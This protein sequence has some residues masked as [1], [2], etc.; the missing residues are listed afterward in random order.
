MFRK[1]V[2]KVD[3]LEVVLAIIVAFLSITGLAPTWLVSPFILAL[4]AVLS[5]AILKN[6]NILEKIERNSYSN[7]NVFLDSFNEEEVDKNLEHAKEVIILGTNLPNVMHRQYSRIEQKLRNGDKIKILIVKSD[8]KLSEIIA[9]RYYEP[10]KIDSILADSN[11]TIE[12]CKELHSI[13]KETK[14][15]LKFRFLDYLPP[16]GAIFVNPQD[17]NGI[18]YL[19]FYTYKT[20]DPKKPKM[21]LHATDSKWYQLFKEIIIALW[22]HANETGCGEGEIELRG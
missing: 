14:G 9:E 19:W 3:N 2:L 6:R 18:I 22:D 12:L 11:T 1:N 15:E 20:R 7:R 21:V 13:A 17:D 4:L 16:F 8:T 10:K 5:V